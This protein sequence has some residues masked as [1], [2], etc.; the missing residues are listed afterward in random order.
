MPSVKEA[1]WESRRVVSMGR[2]REVSRVLAFSSHIVRSSLFPR[3]DWRRYASKRVV[4]ISFTSL[5]SREENFASSIIAS[6]K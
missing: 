5:S 4:Q 6:R 1:R 3:R 2:G